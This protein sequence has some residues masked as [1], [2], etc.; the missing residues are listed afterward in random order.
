MQPYPVVIPVVVKAAMASLAS[1]NGDARLVAK[2]PRRRA[3]AAKRRRCAPRS[4]SDRAE[5]KEISGRGATRARERASYLAFSVL[6][7]TLLT[8]VIVLATYY[9]FERQAESSDALPLGE[10]LS[11]GL[12]TAGAAI[13]MEFWAR[14]AHRSLWHAS[15]WELDEK[16][17]CDLTRPIWDL[18]KSHHKPRQGMWEANDV[19]AI[20]NAVPAT[21]LFAYGF[22]HTGILA[23]LSFGAGLG[24]TVYGLAYMFVHDGL[25]HRRFPVGPIK[26]VPYFQRVEAAHKIHHADTFGGVPYGLFLAEQELKEVGGET[27]IDRVLQ[28]ERKL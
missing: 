6:V 26:E 9:R 15:M 16:L 2:S 13:G 25:V 18:H 10:M 3:N 12:L 27:E 4:S 20:I 21:S 23:G 11:T 22:L 7:T 8:G 28:R 24:I 19:F 1:L 17:K 5:G 14:W